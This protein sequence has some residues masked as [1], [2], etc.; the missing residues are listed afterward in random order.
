MKRIHLKIL[1]PLTIA[2]LFI[3]LTQ[4]SSVNNKEIVSEKGKAQKVES[5][6]D[7]LKSDTLY[8]IK[9]QIKNST[10]NRYIFKL[11]NKADTFGEIGEAYK[12][13][14]VNE[15]E[16]GSSRDSVVYTF[17]TPHKEFMDIPLFEPKFAPLR[18]SN[19]QPKGSYVA[20]QY[21]KKE[22]DEYTVTHCWRLSYKST[23]AWKRVQEEKR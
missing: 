6:K 16:L 2:L 3:F 18:F 15:F 19:N 5:S 22:E 1:F 13:L 10:G 14:L 7:K 20:K 8:T 12:E 4:T 17:E 21:Y 9:F 11:V 23:E